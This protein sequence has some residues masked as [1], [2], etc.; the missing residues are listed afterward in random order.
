[1]YKE[2]LVPLDGSKL[3]ETI[4]PYVRCLA[5]ALNVPVQLLLVQ[6][7][8]TKNSAGPLPGEAYLGNVAKSMLAP[9]RVRY[10]VKTGEPAEVIIKTAAEDPG[11]LITMATRR[12]PKVRSWLLFGGVANNVIRASRNPLVLM[13]ATHEKQAADSV[14]LRT[15]VVPLD[16]S[17]LSEKILTYVVEIAKALQAGVILVRTYSLPRG[18]HTFA[19]RLYVPYVDQ[20]AE[21]VKTEARSYLEV[22]AQELKAKGID[23]VSYQL[24]ED[25]SEVKINELA[26]PDSMLATYTIGRSRVGQ[27][28]GIWNVT[29]RIIRH[30]D[31]SILFVGQ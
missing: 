8:K 28:R 18:S 19:K 21:S 11:T 7:S 15:I 13:R 31:K 24:L 12:R 25:V 3:A 2:I 1:M 10:A 4:L 9:F 17:P 14:N 20:L 5:E 30:W 22:K 16:G 26:P 6:N 23:K 29:E 27:L